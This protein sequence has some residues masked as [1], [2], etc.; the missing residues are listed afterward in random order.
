MES[1]YGDDRAGEWAVCACR[2]LGNDTYS[3]MQY[4][5]ITMPGEGTRIQAKDTPGRNFTTGSAGL[6]PSLR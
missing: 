3:Q 5:S 1:G 2:T 6:F 4:Q